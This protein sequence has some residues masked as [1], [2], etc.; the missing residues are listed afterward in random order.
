MAL[1]PFEGI[2]LLL[3]ALSAVFAAITGLITLEGFFRNKL[4]QLFDDVNYFIFFFL[5]IGYFLYALGEISWYLITNFVQGFS[6][7]GVQDIYWLAGALL[8]LVSF[9]TLS[10]HLFK[11]HPH[12]KNL[13]T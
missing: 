11:K 6:G 12:H 4:K 8:I 5:V 3:V 10:T 2:M 13:L 7:T 9:M 1:D